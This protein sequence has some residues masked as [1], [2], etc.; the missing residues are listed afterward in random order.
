VESADYKG[1]H[2]YKQNA[3]EIFESFFGTSN[4]FAAFGFGDTMP[5]ATKLNKP[6]PKKASSTERQLEC[7]LAELFNGSVKKFF[8]KRIR[9]NAEGEYVEMTKV[10]VITVK[11]GWK[12]GMKIT[13]PNEG[14]EH[15]GI[16]PG[17]IVFTVTELIDATSG[18]SREN[19]NLIYLYRISL[20]DALSDCSLQIP[21]LDKRIISIACPEV[22][23][24]YSEKLVSGEGMPLFKT[25]DVKGDLI[26]RFHILFPKYLNGVKKLKI[27][28]LLANE[29]LQA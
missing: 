8:A 29:D 15:P 14:D 26:I 7:T 6:E 11:P 24:P 12:K 20:A 21:T 4:P 23:S 28:E 1:G 22:V 3:Q 27:R 5:F 18:Y 17:D 9:Q 25:P 16:L 2:H 13:F 19:D 10:L